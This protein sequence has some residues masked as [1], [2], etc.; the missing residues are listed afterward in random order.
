M[1]VD[2][3]RP[4]LFSAAFHL[5]IATSHQPVAGLRVSFLSPSYLALSQVSEPGLHI[6]VGEPPERW[7]GSGQTVDHLH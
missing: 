6:D 1:G 2:C 4:H 7:A 3:F 5:N